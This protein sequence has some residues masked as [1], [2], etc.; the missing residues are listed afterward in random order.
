MIRLKNIRFILL[1]S[2]S[3][4]VTSLFAQEDENQAVESPWHNV[5][6][7]LGGYLTDA[8]TQASIGS[9]TLGLGIGVDF[10]KALG[11][12]RSTFVFQANSLMRFG[13]KKKSFV[14]IGYF[15]INRNANKTLEA[16]V[17]LFDKTFAKGTII[18]SSTNS[19][20]LTS[21]SS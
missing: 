1:I 21:G 2:T 6:V 18:S 7:N 8:S 13:K 15:G 19:T 9:N 20:S 10:E 11:I 3:I 5:E 12:D 4:L 17:E 16:E 14:D